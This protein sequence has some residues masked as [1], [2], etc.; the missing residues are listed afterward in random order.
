MSASVMVVYL[1]GSRTQTGCAREKVNV[2]LPGS[3]ADVVRRVA[4]LHPTLEPLL[5]SVRWAR[6][7]SLV[8]LDAAIADGDEIALLPPVAGGASR[9]RVVSEPLD[10]GAILA[11]AQADDCGALVNFVGTVRNHSRGKAVSQI[12]Y[13]A[14]EPMATQQLDAIAV[15]CEQH[16]PGARIV[17]VHRQGVLQVGDVAI[18][19]AVASPHR[20]AAFD[21]CRAMLERIKIDVPIWKHEVSEDGASWVGWG[22]G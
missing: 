13:E 3:V 14:Y 11:E 9:A 20:D 15:E 2:V 5:G 7:H 6:N 12:T 10:V 8:A 1:G 17:V 4:E 21:A 16:F 19:I 18:V 22:G